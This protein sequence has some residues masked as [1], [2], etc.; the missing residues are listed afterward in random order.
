MAEFEYGNGN[1][2]LNVDMGEEESYDTSWENGGEDDI[3]L[4][5]ALAE[6]DRHVQEGQTATDTAAAA[7]PAPVADDA[8][9]GDPTPVQPDPPKPVPP[10]NSDRFAELDDDDLD[11]LMHNASSKETLKTTKFGI[12]VLK[13]TYRRQTKCKIKAPTVQ[14]PHTHFYVN[15]IKHVHTPIALK[16]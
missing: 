1:F 8:G 4:L 10:P 11:A 15:T 6:I 9:M 14:K 13:S 5:N 2:T 16:A 12:S 7:A 3:D